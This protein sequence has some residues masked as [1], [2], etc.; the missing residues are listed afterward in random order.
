MK[1]ATT[2]FVKANTPKKQR[3]TNQE[4]ATKIIQRAQ[5]LLAGPKED[6]NG[7]TKGTFRGNFKG[8]PCF[9]TMGA[10]REARDQLKLG[11]TVYNLAQD[12]VAAVMKG[13]IIATNDASRTRFPH[14]MFALDL[15]A[16]GAP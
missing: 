6:G 5:V 9:C 12:R 10:L 3:L 2:N 4:K 16:I 15:A 14:V 8:A 1:I 7:W 13:D 11:N